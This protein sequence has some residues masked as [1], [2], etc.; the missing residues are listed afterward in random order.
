MS[1]RQWQRLREW[2]ARA[3]PEFGTA[4]MAGLLSAVLFVLCGLMVVAVGPLV[5]AGPH[6]HPFGVIAIGL[7]AALSG[8]VIGALPWER[9]S[10]SS[11]LWL[12]PLS[13]ALISMHNVFN[14]GNGFRY[15]VFY[16]VVFVWVGLMHPAGTS[17]KFTP[18]LI[19]SYLA[20][21]IWLHDLTT[22]AEAMTY[23]VPV[24][25]LVGECASVIATRIQR[26][27]SAVRANEE[28]LRALVENAQDVISVVDSDEIVRWDSA[29]ITGVLGYG[30]TERVGHNAFDFVR[31]EHVQLARTALQGIAFEPRSLRTVEVEVRH[32]DGSWRWCELRV[33]NLLDDHAVGGFVVN[34][35]DVTERHEAD[36]VERQLA[37]IVESSTDA[38]VG[39]TL[40]GTILSWNPA[41]ERMYQRTAEEMIGQS[42]YAFVPEDRV[43]ELNALYA[44]VAAG[45]AAAI[46]TQRVRADGTYLDISLSMSPVRKST[47]EVAAVAAIARDITDQV[48]A[49]RT[50]ADSESSFRLMFAA[51]PQP[52]WVYDAVTL[53]FLEVNEAAVRHYGYTR[54]EFLSFDIT[55]IRPVEDVELLMEELSTDRAI[56]ETP[57]W[58]HMLADGRTIDVDITSHKLQ[59]AG[60]DAVLVAV[61]DVTDRNAL[62]AQLR[63]QAFHD[64]LT[65]LSNRAL[66]ND[67]VEHAL[68]RRNGARRPIVLLLDL[69]RFK[70]VND[71][72]GHAAGDELLVEAARRLEDSVRLGDSVARLGGDEFAVLLE[73]CTQNAAEL[74]AARLLSAL[75]TPM[76]VAGQEVVTSAS[77][78]VAV[79]SGGMSAGELLRNADVAMYRAK[80]HGGGRLQVFQPA[81]YAAA[82]RQMELTA[83]LRTSIDAQ[84]FVLHYQPVVTLADGAIR[85]VEALTRWIHPELGVMSPLEFIPI[86]EDSGLIVEL[87]AWVMQEACRTA[88]PWPD[89]GINV[90][91]SGRQLADPHIVDHVRRAL[92][93]SG[94]PPERLTLEITESV[95]MQHSEANVRRLRRLRALGVR[96]AIDD[97]GTGYSSLAYLRAFPV[98]ELK[99]DKSFIASLPADEDAI[100][101]VRT[102]VQLAK[103]LSLTTVAEGVETAAQYR[104]LRELGCDEVQGF[105]VSRPT[106]WAD[107]MTLAEGPQVWCDVQS[108]RS[109]AADRCG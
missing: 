92:R 52:M 6:V 66:F 59:F 102:I 87:G 109:S 78:G 84:Q 54:Q 29:S 103:S 36:A 32:N 79:A 28:R 53:Q 11:T 105:Y 65:G 10:R 56:R 7:I 47:G 99:I 61:R 8:P 24:C 62:D 19:A 95:L 48:K 67:R 101:L 40:D 63:H 89:V 5:P 94:L 86:A 60:R 20:P 85:S 90:N 2:P 12:V 106:E 4:K 41:A 18:L 51:N 50:L 70:L 42:V 81:M 21:A 76:S 58:R 17:A 14:G 72:L 82:A 93:E 9:W 31:P 34:I 15:D 45:E 55:E 80:A 74:Q 71:S 107:V 96:L 35:T 13:F 1:V 104:A 39:Q 83:A 49:R 73:D 57:G 91:L 69:D 100:A 38:I 27:E 108:A 37:A 23:A 98:H 44:S 97:F 26:S 75:A 64:S 33:R 25:V 46:E 16:F 22:L 88:A 30:A 77:I 68:G 43:D 3:M